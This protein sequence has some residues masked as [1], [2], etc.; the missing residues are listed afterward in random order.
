MYEGNQNQ[1]K[2]QPVHPVWA[3]VL[4]KNKKKNQYTQQEKIK[5]A[6]TFGCFVDSGG[7]FYPWRSIQNP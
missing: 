6:Q 2:A 7:M 3:L 4:P 1:G 5:Q